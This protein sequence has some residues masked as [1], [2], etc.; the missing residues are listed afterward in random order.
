MT[1]DLKD[2]NA[3]LRYSVEIALYD[4]LVI[5]LNKDLNLANIE[6]S[7]SDDVEPKVLKSELHEMVYKLINDRFADYLNLLY[8]IDVSESQV[9]KLD[10][11]DALRLSEQITFLI[12]KREWEKVWYRNKYN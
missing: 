12:L 9:K 2:S 6:L 4:K 7:F 1:T 5:Q 10:G 11:S 8:V 3:L